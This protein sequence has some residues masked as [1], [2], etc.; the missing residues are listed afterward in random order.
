MVQDLLLPMTG[1]AG[2]GNAMT[3]A[4][5]LA[6]A[7]D[8]HLSVVQPVNLPL[9]IPGPWGITPEAMLSGFYADFRAEAD[10]QAAELRNRLARESISW[11]VRVDECRIA[12]PPR[13]MAFQARYADLSVMAAPAQGADDS[14][15]ARAFFSAMLFESGRPVLVAPPRQPA[16]VPFRHVVIAWKPTREATRALH[17]SLAL[18]RGATSIDVVIVDPVVSDMDH[19]ADPGVDIATH[20]SRHDVRV[21]VVSIPRAGGTVAAALLRHAAESKA[22]LLVAGG[23]GHSRLREWVLGGTTRELLRDLHLPILFSH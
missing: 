11:E 1:T 6:S 22:Q 10:K 12:D 4:I 15:V 5:A 13:G 21:N 8:A 23:Y 17:D 18:L 3:W 19:G 9:P 16:Q 20:L 7:Q 2:D 14:A